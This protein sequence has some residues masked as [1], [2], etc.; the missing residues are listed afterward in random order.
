MKILKPHEKIPKPDFAL[1]D[2]DGTISKLRNGWDVIMRDLFIDM[3]PG[4]REEV[5]ALAEKY[6]DESCGIPTIRQMQFLADQVK[7]RTGSCL[8]AWQYKEKFA[9]RMMKKVNE[10][11]EEI[12]SGKRPAEYYLVPGSVEF[13]KALKARGIPILLASGTDEGDV[14]S[15]ASALGV[16]DLFDIVCGAAVREDMCAKEQTLRKYASP[17]KKMLIV[18]DGKVEIMLGCE[19][20]A[21]TIGVASWDQY[22]ELPE[23]FEP[24]KEKRLT[25]AGA[26]LLIA[27][28]RDCDAIID[29]M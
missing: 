29:W 9:E 2:F 24:Y 27:D 21:V 3:I 8:E 11:K 10:R 20:G 28:Y 26:H 12:R 14:R 17:D 25:D 16:L 15:E 1:L 7:E 4:D 23:G 19:L 13:I 18:G 22:G 5:K 6:I